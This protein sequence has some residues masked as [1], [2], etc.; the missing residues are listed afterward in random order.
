MLKRS[1]GVLVALTAPRSKE[2]AGHLAVCP[3]TP[4]ILHSRQERKLDHVAV[5][6]GGRR[7]TSIRVVSALT[8]CCDHILSLSFGFTMRLR[9]HLRA[10]G[11]L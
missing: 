5:H 6:A 7:P 2:K 9:T 10:F 4:P 1:V 3:S 8:M 11:L